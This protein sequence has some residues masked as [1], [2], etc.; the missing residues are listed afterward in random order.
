MITGISEVRQTVRSDSVRKQDQEK[1]MKKG[2]MGATAAVVVAAA[3][4]V[5]ALPASAVLMEWTDDKLCGSQWVGSKST[6]TGHVEHFHFNVPETTY[7]ST[8]WENGSAYTAHTFVQ[9]HSTGK[10]QVY[11]GG[12][13]G[14]KNSSSNNL[15]CWT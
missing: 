4:L 5:P 10:V 13:S 11:A 2:L 1:L 8:S 12:F 15:S 7:S 3:V 14:A 9:Y 6:G